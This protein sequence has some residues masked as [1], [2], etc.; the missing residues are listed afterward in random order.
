MEIFKDFGVQPILLLAQIINFVILLCILKRFLYKPI[1]K[2]LEER[3]DKI[4]TSMKQAEEIQKR[5]DE[6]A[7]K[8]G[9][10]LTQAKG[11]A[12]KIVEEAKDEAKKLAEQIQD[13]TKQR[14]VETLERSQESLELAN[15]SAVPNCFF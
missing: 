10:L 9:E 3:R 15:A 7:T 8:Q 12:S 14:V 6:V 13:E 2:M 5:F 4:E 1:L 11:E